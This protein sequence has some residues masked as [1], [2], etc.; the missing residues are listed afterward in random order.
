MLIRLEDAG[1]EVKPHELFL[2]D[3]ENDRLPPLFGQFCCRLA[4]QPY[5]REEPVLVGS[6]SV[7]YPLN[8]RYSGDRKPNFKLIFY[9]FHYLKDKKVKYLKKIFNECVIFFL[10]K[11][12]HLG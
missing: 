5:C 3:A 12:F 6:L 7:R 2:E 11:V 8:E 9:I 10:Y 4:V 1:E